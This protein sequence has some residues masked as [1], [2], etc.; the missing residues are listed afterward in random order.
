MRRKPARAGKF[1]SCPLLPRAQAHAALKTVS[2]PQ[3]GT[4][5]YGKV[6]GQINEKAGAMGA[7]LKSIHTQY[8]DRPQVGRLFDVKG[9]ESIAAFFSV[10]N[11]NHGGGQVAGL[12]IATK[13]SNTDVEVGVVYDKRSQEFENYQLG[14]SVIQDNQGNTHGTFWNADATALVQSDPSR[15]EY[16]NAPNYWKGVD[17]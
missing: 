15:Y 7:V 8:G 16:V 3:G 13:A 10:N 17:Y 11:R 9:T 12:M 6:D 1:P 2:N 14:Y 5:M 4:V